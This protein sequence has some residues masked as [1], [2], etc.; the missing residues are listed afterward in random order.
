MQI[1]KNQILDMLRSR[2][3]N[4]KVDQADKD[5]PEKV[6]TDQHSELLTKVGINPKDLLGGAGGLLGG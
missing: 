2:G 5:L 3:D 6:D 1:D 4:A